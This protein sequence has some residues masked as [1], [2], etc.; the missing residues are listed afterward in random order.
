MSVRNSKGFTLIE[1]MIVLIIG[2]VLLE[3]CSAQLHA[4]SKQYPDIG[5][6][7]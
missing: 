2:A 1:L 6:C 4:S 5:S 3:Y 7:W